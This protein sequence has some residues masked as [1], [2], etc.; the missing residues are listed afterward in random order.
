MS[1]L[2]WEPELLWRMSMAAL[3]SSIVKWYRSYNTYILADRTERTTTTLISLARLFSLGLTK[4]VLN[5]YFGPWFNR[6]I[7]F[8]CSLSS[9]HTC[10]FVCSTTTSLRTSNIETANTFSFGWIMSLENESVYTWH[11]NT[12]ELSE[13][14][15]SVKVHKPVEGTIEYFV[16]SNKVAV[17]YI[18]LVRGVDRYRHILQILGSLWEGYKNDSIVHIHVIIGSCTRG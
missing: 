8:L 15:H 14:L 7:A 1:A 2:I 18:W 17:A 5:E 13:E 11:A 12:K 3:T 10:A 16:L 6:A 9:N 4:N